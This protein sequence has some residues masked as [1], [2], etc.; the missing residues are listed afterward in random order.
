MTRSA[1]RGHRSCL[2]PPATFWGGYVLERLITV[3]GVGP[4]TVVDFVVTVDDVTRFRGV[5]QVEGYVG[6]VPREWSSSETQRRGQITEAAVG[7]VFHV[8]R[9]ASRLVSW[10]RPHGGTRICR[11]RHGHAAWR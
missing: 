2:G 9:E 6:L 11:S 10:T 4:I 5:H 1:G 7:R 3:P 8:R